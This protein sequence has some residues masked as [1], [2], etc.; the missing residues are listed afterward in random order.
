LLMRA[1]YPMVDLI[2]RDLAK[3]VESALSQDDTSLSSGRLSR[4]GFT[5]FW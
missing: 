3:P 2:E 4:T 1:T 5:D